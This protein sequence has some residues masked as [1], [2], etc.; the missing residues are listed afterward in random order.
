MAWKGLFV[1]VA[2]GKAKFID[3]ALSPGIICIGLL[4]EIVEVK[5]SELW[6]LSISEWQ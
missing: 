4:V 6:A 2:E 5:E 1:L 3:Q